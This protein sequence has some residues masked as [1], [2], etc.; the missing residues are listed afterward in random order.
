MNIN[1]KLKTEKFYRENQRVTKIV[2]NDTKL[3]PVQLE[4]GSLISRHRK[5]YRPKTI[6]QKLSA[7]IVARLSDYRLM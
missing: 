4:S 2:I 6:G 7:T 5:N 1:M 3:C